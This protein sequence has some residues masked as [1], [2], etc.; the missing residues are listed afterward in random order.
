MRGSHI[1]RGEGDESFSVGDDPFSKWMEEHSDIFSQAGRFSVTKLSE[2]LERNA[3]AI[4]SRFDTIKETVS[5]ASE[6][7]V[8]AMKIVGYVLDV[9]RMMCAGLKSIC[10]RGKAILVSTSSAAV[11]FYGSVTGESDD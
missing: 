4:F 3:E 6:L 8:Y 2:A 11:K 7:L 9:L 5:K 10:V 1:M